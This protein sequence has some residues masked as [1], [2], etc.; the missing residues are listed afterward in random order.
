MKHEPPQD[1]FDRNVASHKMTVLLDQGI[2]RHLRFKRPGTIAYWFD[3]ITAPGIL[4]FSGDMGGYTF[5]RLDDMFEFFRSGA[6]R[7]NPQYWAEKVEAECKT[8]GIKKFSLTK[9]RGIL[10]EYVR[11]WIRD[12]RCCCTRV[13]R[14]ELWQEI[15]SVV[16]NAGENRMYNAAYY[17]THRLNGNCGFRFNDLWD[18]NFN[19]FTERFIWCCRALVWAIKQYDAAMSKEPAMNEIEDDIAGA[20]NR[21]LR[22]W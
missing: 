3:I 16:L 4:V 8:D 9:F 11:D 5:R 12:N 13:E 20:N 14:R 22:I 2:Y 21:A 10:R 19:E 17:F 6:G 15:N 7:I 1:E 18:H